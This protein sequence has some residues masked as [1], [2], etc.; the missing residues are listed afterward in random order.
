[1]IHAVVIALILMPSTKLVELPDMEIVNRGSFVI[2]ATVDGF[3]CYGTKAPRSVS[4]HRAVQVMQFGESVTL[5]DRSSY[6]AEDLPKEADL[7]ATDV[8]SVAAEKVHLSQNSRNLG[9]GKCP[10]KP[11][12]RSSGFLLQSF[13]GHFLVSAFFNSHKSLH[14]TLGV[15]N[16]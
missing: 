13:F 2:A 15:V 4:C 11:E 5:L 7:S 14:S 8:T 3:L 9:D 1:M 6:Q 12:N 16:E 10:G